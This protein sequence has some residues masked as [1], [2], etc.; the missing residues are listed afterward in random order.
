MREGTNYKGILNGDITALPLHQSLFSYDR[1]TPRDQSRGVGQ[2][3][4][5]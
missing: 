4:K 5:I 2:L 3:D 1:L